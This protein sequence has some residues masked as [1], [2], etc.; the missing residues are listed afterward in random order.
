M[1]PE[2]SPEGGGSG[3]PHS[4]T[5]ITSF[6]LAAASFQNV[7]VLFVLCLI[8]FLFC[9]SYFLPVSHKMFTPHTQ[10]L[11]ILQSYRVDVC[12]SYSPHSITAKHTP[13]VLCSLGVSW[14]IS[15]LETDQNLH[16]V[17][18]TWIQRQHWQTEQSWKHCQRFFISLYGKWA[19]SGWI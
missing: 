3:Q 12:H 18:T 11:H 8:C 9:P 17:L 14:F 1:A 5:G 7:C 6:D 10:V 19:N 2:C 16:S 4:K 15:K 13:Y